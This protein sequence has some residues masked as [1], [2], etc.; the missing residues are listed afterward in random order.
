MIG[1]T[2]SN[3]P[4][5][6]QQHK[7]TEYNPRIIVRSYTF[8]DLPKSMHHPSDRSN[9]AL[10]ECIIRFRFF[11]DFGFPKIQF[12]ASADEECHPFQKKLHPALF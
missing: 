5:P 1:K 11:T 12:L 6:I 10:E 7:Q 2:I 8:S 4:I 3:E 9:I